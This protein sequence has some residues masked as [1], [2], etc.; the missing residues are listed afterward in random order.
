MS[1]FTEAVRWILDPAN[2]QGSTGIG[3]R[4]QEHLVYSGLGVGIACAVAILAGLVIGHTRRGEFIAVSVANLGRAIPSFAILSIVFQIM[5]DYLPGI[6][7]GLGKPSIYPAVPEDRPRSRYALT[8]DTVV[9]VSTML[10]DAAPKI[11]L[12]SGAQPELRSLQHGEMHTCWN[13]P[14]TLR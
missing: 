12:A 5:L 14:V 13:L 1:V 6:A 11:R 9:L 3:F 7:F 2:W 10:L 8:R 4:L